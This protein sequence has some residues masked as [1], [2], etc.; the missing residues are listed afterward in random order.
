MKKFTPVLLASVMLFGA[1]ACADG[2]KTSA[3]APNT[4][5]DPA[6]IPDADE[7]QDSQKDAQSQVRQNQLNSDI[8]AREQRN[9]ALNDGAA[10]DR[11]DD[12][13]ESEVRSKL[14]AN[15]PAGAL[16][17][18]AEDG[19]VMV[20]GTVPTQEQFERIEPL[21]KEIKGVQS[22]NVKAAVAPA[23]PKENN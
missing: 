1:V 6:E 8:R 4:I 21:A 10:E 16:V 12:D 11:S 2:A 5:T 18:E 3:D 23:Q 13:L 9:N 17:I 20:S 7:A 19:V 15:L 14:E 22:V